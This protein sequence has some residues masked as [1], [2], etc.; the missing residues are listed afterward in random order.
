MKYFKL[1][2]FKSSEESQELLVES[3]FTV[4]QMKVLS[5]AALRVIPPPR[6]LASVGV[7]IELSS[8]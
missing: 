7:V 3:V 2:T 1:A 5:A 8:I 4:D 6:A